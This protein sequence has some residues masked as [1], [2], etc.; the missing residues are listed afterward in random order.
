MGN[1][2]AKA[3]SKQTVKKIPFQRAK[4]PPKQK[5]RFKTPSKQNTGDESLID[6]IKVVALTV[7]ATLTAAVVLTIFVVNPSMPTG[8]GIAGKPS[9][10]KV[11]KVKPPKAL[12][13]KRKPTKAPNE[14]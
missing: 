13:G 2:R 4:T 5:T 11:K 10:T 12:I 8:G 1:T 14:Y 9:T 3:P 7:T 6:K